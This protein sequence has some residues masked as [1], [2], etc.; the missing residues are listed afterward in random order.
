MDTQVHT[1][2]ETRHP[3]N[4]RRLSETLATSPKR[5]V[6]RRADHRRESRE[7]VLTL[8]AFGWSAFEE[9]A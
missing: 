3:R 4:L 2:P 5:R 1:Q 9:V 7:V 6:G 8:R